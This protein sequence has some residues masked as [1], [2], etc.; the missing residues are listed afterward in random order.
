MQANQTGVMWTVIIASLVL[1]VAG[2]FAVSSLNNSMAL[3]ADGLNDISVPSAAEIVSLIVI[4]TINTDAIDN[5]CEATD[6]CNDW[7]IDRRYINDAVNQVRDDLEDNNNKGL[8]RLIK[9]MYGINEKG[10]IELLHFGNLEAI[11]KVR[12]SEELDSDFD[13]SDTMEISVEYVVK[14]EYHEDGQQDLT[15]DY[16]KITATLY[17]LEDGI[18]YSEVKDVVAED[19]SKNKALTSN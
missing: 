12:S 13:F 18:G 16:V 9:S 1:L 14:V 3:V 15:T 7:R 5:V 17:E 6:G 4:P 19:W 8:F 2:A 10:D 11:G